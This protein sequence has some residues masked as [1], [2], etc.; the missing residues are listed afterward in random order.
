MDFKPLSVNDYLDLKFPDNGIIEQG[1]LTRQSR[2]IIG[3]HPGVGKS[4][5]CTQIG[6]ELSRGL[7][8]VDTFS[9]IKVNVLYIQEE[10]GPRSYQDRLAKVRTHYQNT[11]NFWVISSAGFSFDDPRL[12]I[13]LKQYIK[14]YKIDVVMI[15]PLYKVHGRRENDTTELSQLVQLIDRIINEFDV[16]VVL[17][18]HLRKPFVTYR[19]DSVD[20]GAMDFRGSTVI[21]AWADTM[22]RLEEIKSKNRVSMSFLKARNAPA[23]IPGID[24][25]LDRDRLRFAPAE[26]PNTPI[27]TER[28]F[29]EIQELLSSVP[30]FSMSQNFVI[31][32]I[33]AKH[34]SVN[35]RMVKD[36]IKKLSSEGKLLSS[37]GLLV[38]TNPIK[39][40]AV[41]TDDAWE[42]DN[43]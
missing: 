11:G 18:H 35:D 7:K 5:L 26:N 15:D 27:S 12:L 2:L 36:T 14:Q 33:K 19:G 21:P 24:L 41:T 43:W 37:K 13:L 23:E 9:C 22:I 42:L 29:E 25:F 20:Q 28:L 38:I 8:V 10:I 3:G 39:A 32:R 17:V 4:V 6:I 40:V 31:S 16:S 34:P 1:I 30:S